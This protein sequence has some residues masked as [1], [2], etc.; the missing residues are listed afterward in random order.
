MS[1]SVRTNNAPTPAIADIFKG[2][3]H[4]LTIFPQEYVDSFKLFLKGDKPYLTCLVTDKPCHAGTQS[5]I[6]YMRPRCVICGW[7]VRSNRKRLGAPS[8]GPPTHLDV[9]RPIGYYVPINLG[10]SRV[11]LRIR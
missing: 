4:A 6:E 8:P 2:S 1:S 10:E 7:F 11:A 5:Y 9:R 3:N